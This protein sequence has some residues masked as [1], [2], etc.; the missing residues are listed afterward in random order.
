[1]TESRQRGVA[2]KLS[3]F[4]FNDTSD[5]DFKRACGKYL[6][7]RII[8][9]W[10]QAQQFLIRPRS[11]FMSDDSSRAP[12]FDIGLV[13][14][15]YDDD[16]DLK[17]QSWQW[18]YYP[19]DKIIPAGP[20]LALPFLGGGAAR[21]IVPYSAH[22]AAILKSAAPDRQP[23]GMLCLALGL[24][25][26]SVHG[27]VT[28]KRADLF[29][30]NGVGRYV[31]DSNPLSALKNALPDFRRKLEDEIKA[32]RILLAPSSNEWCHS[33][34]E[35]IC[36]PREG[37]IPLTTR[38]KPGGPAVEDVVLVLWSEA[39]RDSILL[40]S[41]F[42]DEL[43][44]PANAD[45]N[46]RTSAVEKMA[47]W[48]EE[49][50]KATQYRAELYK[51]AAMV[52][53]RLQEGFDKVFDADSPKDHDNT[54]IGKTSGKRKRLPLHG[55]IEYYTAGMSMKDKD[56]VLTLVV[57]LAHAHEWSSN[58][59]SHGRRNVVPPILGLGDGSPRS[60][61]DLFGTRRKS[62]RAPTAREFL[63]DKSFYPTENTRL[64]LFEKACVEWYLCEY[65]NLKE[66]A[67][68]DIPPWA[69]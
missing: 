37:R 7:V 3:V 36:S 4:D 13:D 33:L 61:L 63:P 58:E 29:G 53:D 64:N 1:M 54:P 6:D 14:V 57:I 56:A 69:R 15:D 11:T 22:W 19:E 43:G 16:P 12:A 60:Y 34:R 27:R 44:F 30:D 59:P 26:A 8:S 28:V 23:D 20:I 62:K 25:M 50:G 68:E 2:R 35:I 38:A 41:I 31:A 18:A 52:M 42:A 5:N 48:V 66:L 45:A 65:R 10:K 39:G 9:R 46:V 24:L 32:G 21:V 55:A 51:A 67:K 17:G 47:E 49:L 40:T